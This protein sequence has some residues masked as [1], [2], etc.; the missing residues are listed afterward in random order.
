MGRLDF[1]HWTPP[2]SPMND[3]LN[4]PEVE[5]RHEPIVYPTIDPHQLQLMRMRSAL[6]NRASKPY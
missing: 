4:T 6:V 5:V 3:L 2:K 1:T